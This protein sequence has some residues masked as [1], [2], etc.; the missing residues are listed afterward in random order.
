MDTSI[1][2]TAIISVVVAILGI[3]FEKERDRKAKI[4]E[5]NFPRP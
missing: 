2:V 4:H 1:I 5:I 3:I